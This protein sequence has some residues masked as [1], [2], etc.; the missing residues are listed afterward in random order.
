MQVVD[1]QVVGSKARDHKTRQ[2]TKSKD[3]TKARPSPRP[4]PR[5]RPGG[6]KTKTQTQTKTKFGG[7]GQ[8]KGSK[9]SGNPDAS[10]RL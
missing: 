7:A 9:E 1:F 6:T 10:G 5:L 2:E 4:K 3:K 8:T